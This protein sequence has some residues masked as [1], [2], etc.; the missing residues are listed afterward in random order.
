MTNLLKRLTSEAV[1]KA[2]KPKAT[3][4]ASLSLRGNDSLPSVDETMEKIR[5]YNERHGD[6]RTKTP[7]KK[8]GK[9]NNLVTSETS[10]PVI[11][12]RSKKSFISKAK[13]GKVSWELVLNWKTLRRSD[14]TQKLEYKAG[15]SY[16]EGSDEA[17]R[18]LK[19]LIQCGGYKKEDVD[20]IFVGRQGTLEA[21]N[22]E[23]SK[24]ASEF[25]K[26]KGSG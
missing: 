21:Y 3:R 23:R 16:K 26:E 1:A 15:L 9:P 18:I 14:T 4:I 22:A 7:T 24:K 10:L 2:S 12:N 11:S 8:D 13:D 25:L 19:L 17:V 20:I 5:K 6:A